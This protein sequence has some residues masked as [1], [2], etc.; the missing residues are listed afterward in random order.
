[1]DEIWKPVVGFEGL[2]EVSNLGRVR[3]LDCLSFSGNKTSQVVGRLIRGRVMAQRLCR[4][5]YWKIN[6]SAKPDENGKRKKHRVSVH[7]LVAMAFIPD[8][9]NFGLDVNHRDFNPK[10]NALSNLE[11][12]TRKMNLQHSAAAGR[13]SV[14][15]GKESRYTP[16]LWATVI[17]ALAG[18]KPVAEIAARME[19][20]IS[21]VYRAR[22]MFKD[23][24]HCIT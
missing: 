16:A 23:L 14:P 5:G 19:I 11:W 18:G 2:Y 8:D 10:N 17:R 1:M 15:R 22:W 3:S 9:P 6:L 12:A 20:P 24:M 7:R 4:Q 21:Q 13:M